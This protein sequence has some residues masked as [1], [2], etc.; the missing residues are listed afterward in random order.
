MDKS[1]VESEHVV[2]RLWKYIS[3]SQTT[4]AEKRPRDE[5]SDES[6]SGRKRRKRAAP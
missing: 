6:R 1:D 3:S 4:G 5:E 2:T